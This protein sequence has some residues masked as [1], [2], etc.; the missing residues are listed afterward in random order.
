[1]ADSLPPTPLPP[2]LLHLLRRQQPDSQPTPGTPLRPP[3]AQRI[4]QLDRVKA[5]LEQLR[6]DAEPL[7]SRRSTRASRIQSSSRGG[8]RRLVVSEKCAE[9]GMRRGKRVRP[10]RES[11]DRGDSP[12]PADRSR[13]AALPTKVRFHDPTGEPLTLVVADDSAPRLVA[14]GRECFWGGRHRVRGWRELWRV[15]RCRSRVR[16]RGAE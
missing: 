4:A 13:S 1:M 9:P 10:Q 15:V 2:R 14:S 5:V 6:G 12:T 11:W 8:P 3:F 16:E 7:G